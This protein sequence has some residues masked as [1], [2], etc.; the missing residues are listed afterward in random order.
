MSPYSGSTGER[1][2]NLPKRALLIFLNAFA[3]PRSPSGAPS[4]S[5]SVYAAPRSSRCFSAGKT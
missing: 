1:F 4:N 5:H 3:P 2:M